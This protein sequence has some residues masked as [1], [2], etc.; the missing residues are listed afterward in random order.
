[1]K[2]TLF[3]M[4]HIGSN[5][6]NL[7]NVIEKN[8]RF[9]CFNTG[10][11]Y[12]HPEDVNGLTS[13]LHRCENAASVWCD[14]ILHNK[15]FAMKN[16]CQHYKFI[17]WVRSRQESIDDLIFKYRYGPE[18][19]E[20]YYDYRLSGLGQYFRRCPKSIYNPDLGSNSFLSA[21]F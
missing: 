18:Q 9:Q 14:V 20:N 11:S 2:R 6:E 15:D 10:I 17:Y 4:T 8:V 7:V 16:L 3:I 19:A 21:I 12:K 13:L 1:M 5:W